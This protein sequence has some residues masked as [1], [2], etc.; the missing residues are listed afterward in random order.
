MVL[1]VDQNFRTTISRDFFELMSGDY[2]GAGVGREVYVCATNPNLVM[3]LENTAYSFQNANEWQLWEILNDMPA[4]KYFA[5]CHS[6]SP[7]GTVLLMDRT[8]PLHRARYPDKMPAFFTDMK[9]TNFGMIGKH[10][11]CHDYGHTNLVEMGLTKRMKKAEWWDE[12]I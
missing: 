10:L 12:G 9:R 8:Y 2:L 1:D 3:K 6:I 4:A 11:V 7:C 5:P